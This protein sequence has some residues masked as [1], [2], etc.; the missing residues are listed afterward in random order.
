MRELDDLANDFALK[1]PPNYAEIVEMLKQARSVIEEGINKPFEELLLTQSRELL[2]LDLQ[3]DGYAD[4]AA[5]LR[6]IFQ[7]EA[8]RGNCPMIKSRRSMTTSSQFA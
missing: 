2:V 7:I 3:R 1:K 5:A 8:A 4:Q 6:Q